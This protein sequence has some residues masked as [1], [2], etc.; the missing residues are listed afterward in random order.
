MALTCL[1]C[2]RIAQLDQKLSASLNLPSPAHLTHDQ[3]HATTA[4]SAM[5]SLA[6]FTPKVS[7]PVNE[8]KERDEQWKQYLTRYT[9]NDPCHP[10]CQ[11]LYKDHYHCN[12]AHCGMLFK[13]KD[14]VRD[15]AK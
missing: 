15:H 6:G 1:F 9:A 3:Q 4:G 14:G 8:K 5:T 2:T 10:R 13:S 12:T 11:H 7:P